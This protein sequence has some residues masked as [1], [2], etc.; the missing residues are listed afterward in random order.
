LARKP[1]DV[2]HVEPLVVRPVVA[3]RL[4][5]NCSEATLWELI[6]SEAVKSFRDGGARYITVQSIKDYIASRLG[7]T[8]PKRATPRRPRK[9]ATATAA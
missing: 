8:S 7:G 4:L 2:S 5:G 9:P 6:N 1:D 3:R